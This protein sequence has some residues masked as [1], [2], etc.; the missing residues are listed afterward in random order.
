MSGNE[1]GAGKHCGV[2][3]SVQPNK[4]G[5]VTKGTSVFEIST[6]GTGAMPTRETEDFAMLTWKSNDSKSSVAYPIAA[7]SSDEEDATMMRS[8]A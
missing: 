6:L 3:V 5:W 4:S 2:V 1:V 8:S 7:A